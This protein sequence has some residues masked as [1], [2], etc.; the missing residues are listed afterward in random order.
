[1]WIAD[2]PA[3]AAASCRRDDRAYHLRSRAP[4]LS[5]GFWP[6]ILALVFLSLSPVAWIEDSDHSA[7][8]T[9]FT[10]TCLPRLRRTGCLSAELNAAEVENNRSVAFADSSVRLA[11]VLRRSGRPG[12]LLHNLRSRWYF[13]C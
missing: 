9:C 8:E 10:A 4:S 13:I 7:A 5:G 3:S 11:Q 12:A 2:Q 1:M 6:G